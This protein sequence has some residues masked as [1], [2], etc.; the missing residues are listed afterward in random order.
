MSI[1]IRATMPSDEP[2][3]W[4]MLYESIHTKPGAA[5]PDRSILQE[6][7]IAHYLTGWGRLGDRAF[8]A[9]D[10]GVPVGAA[11]YRLMPE[12]DP[13][14][15]FV[16][17]D[18]PE[19]GIALSPAARGQGVGTRLMEHLIAQARADG[20]RGLSLSVDPRNPALRLYERLGFTYVGTDDGDSWTM[21]L[22]ISD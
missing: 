6:P 7:S 13:G 18:T 22:P 19:L 20:Y 14:Y 10:G 17:A 2:F 8:L 4:E 1:R 21:V 5:R 15:G 12:S 11:W 16:A 9:E 3:L